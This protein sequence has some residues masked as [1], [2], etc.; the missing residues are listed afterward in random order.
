MEITNLARTMYTL[1]MLINRDGKGDDLLLENQP[2]EVQVE[3]QKDAD[4]VER[5]LERSK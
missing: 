1:E 5:F 3:W 2:E 4:A